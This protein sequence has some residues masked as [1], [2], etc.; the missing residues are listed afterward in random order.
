MKHL[1]ITHLVKASGLLGWTIGCIFQSRAQETSVTDF[2]E[3][4]K[5]G[6]A[7]AS[8]IIN[9]NSWIF[10]E[11]LSG[12]AAGDVKNDNYAARLRYSATLETS[13]TLET[14][15][16][17]ISGVS[18][19][20]CRSDF[21]GDREGTSP[22]IVAQVGDGTGWASLDTLGLAGID[23]LTEASF[24]DIGPGYGLFRIIAIAGDEGKRFNID[25]ISITYGEIA[26]PPVIDTLSAL[27]EDFAE[28]SG[29]GIGAF[30]PYSDIGDD[31]WHCVNVGHDGNPYAA[32]MNG[33]FAADESEA[34]RDWLISAHQYDFSG[35]TA[36][37][38]SFW[39]KKQY[40]GAAILKIM[41][42]T[43]YD[44]LGNPLSATWE[45]IHMTSAP[46]EDWTQVSGID[47]LEYKDLPFFLAF[48]YEC[49]T[50][51]AFAYYLDDIS[52]TDEPSGIRQVTDDHKNLVVV[53]NPTSNQIRLLLTARAPGSYKLRIYDLNGRVIYS[54]LYQVKEGKN[55]IVISHIH[56]LK[57]IYM[58][59]VQH[60]EHAQTSTVK[61]VVK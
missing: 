24:E 33:G 27:N 37:V 31:S 23:D 50:D 32:R 8:A 21:S 54:N 28:C 22:I 47:L 9:G 57:G 40:E 43:D 3:G 60:A 5:S 4:T 49:G 17:D 53:G 2:E 56:L 25:D 35:M 34:N 30:R 13:L 51:G 12:N 55:D 46:T 6:Y 52:V 59:K 44:G 1:N 7:S 29:I 38:L 42:S 45:E 10:N 48:T 16:P 39:N 20:Y 26:G 58:I 15:M 19:W 41:V 61:A 18:F 36:P 14:E 11:A